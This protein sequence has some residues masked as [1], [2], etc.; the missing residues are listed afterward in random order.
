MNLSEKAHAVK[1]QKDFVDFLHA[2]ASDLRQNKDSWG[3]PELDQFL[4]AFAAWVT[5]MNGYYINMDIPQPENLNWSAIAD[6]FMG[7]RVYE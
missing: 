7:A 1:T 3:N 2:L 4:E 6:M 5:D